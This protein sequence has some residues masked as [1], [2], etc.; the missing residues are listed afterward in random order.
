MEKSELLQRMILRSS[1]VFLLLV[2]SGCA[3]IFPEPPPPVVTTIPEPEPE[4]E[5]APPIEVPPVVERAPTIELPAEPETVSPH[6]AIVLSESLPAYVDVASELLAYLEDYKVY[7]LSNRIRSPR[8]A[9]AAIAE[10]D[11]KLVVAIGLY[12]SLYQDR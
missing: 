9:F 11:A 2:L 3:L 5:P 6:V 10:S 4:P 8:Q 12:A 1:L 7:D